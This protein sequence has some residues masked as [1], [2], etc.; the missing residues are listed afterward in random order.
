MY[1]FIIAVAREKLTDPLSGHQS[2]EEARLVDSEISGNLA[3]F[4]KM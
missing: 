3:A 2:N 1:V 4:V